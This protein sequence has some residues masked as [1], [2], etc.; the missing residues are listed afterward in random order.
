MQLAYVDS[1]NTGSKQAEPRA[2]PD[3][4]PG[5][6]PLTLNLSTATDASERDFTENGV[7]FKAKVMELKTVTTVKALK[8]KREVRAS[9]ARSHSSQGDTT[10]LP[11][12]RKAVTI[13]R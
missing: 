1:R 4:E 12:G 10:L 5:K 3:T 8:Y 11:G 9:L 7:T 13:K 6:V 2:A